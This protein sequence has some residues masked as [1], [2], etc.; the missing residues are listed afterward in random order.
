LEAARSSGDYPKNIEWRSVGRDH[1]IPDDIHQQ[2]IDAMPA[3]FDALLAKGYNF[4]TVSELI[5]MNHPK[6][7][8]SP[9]AVS[10]TSDK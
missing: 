2:T 6:P 8:S 9:A 3:T 5:A 7:P 10:R 1:F 4:V